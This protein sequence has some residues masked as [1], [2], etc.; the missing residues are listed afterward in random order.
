[1]LTK[2]AVTEF[3]KDICM[4][5]AQAVQDTLNSVGNSSTPLIVAQ[6]TIT[7][8][9]CYNMVKRNAVP[10]ATMLVCLACTAFVLSPT[11]K[12]IK[13]LIKHPA[14]QFED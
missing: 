4:G 3:R 8:T 5:S 7:C 2:D 1:M 13:A 12:S 9:L 14:Q 11:S 6:G 10:V